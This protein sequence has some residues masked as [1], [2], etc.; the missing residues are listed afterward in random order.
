MPETKR[1]NNQPDL[2]G[3]YQYLSREL[4][5]AKD[6]LLMEVRMASAQIGSLHG[7]LKDAH[8]KSASAVSQ[9]IRFSYK[10]NQTIYDGLA[11][12]LTK[13]VGE[14]LN[15]MEEILAE[16]SKL[17]LLIDSLEELKEGYMTMQAV[18]NTTQALVD[19]EVNPKLD[20]VGTILSGEVTPKLEAIVNYLASDLNPK[21]DAIQAKQALLDDIQALA[22]E[23]N[24]KLVYL[25][26]EE[27]Y[28]RLVEA[29]SAKTEETA[30]T[31][32][33]QVV[34]AIAAL[35]TAENVDYSRIVE[36]VGD[37][38]MDILHQIKGEDPAPVLPVETK[39][40]YDRIICGAAEK[41]VESLPYPEKVDYN[42]IEQALALDPNALADT[43]A[44]RIVIPETPAPEALNYNLIAEMVAERVHVPEVTIPTLEINYDVLSDMVAE[45]VTVPAA[46]AVEIDYE[47]LSDM[48]A[49]KVTVPA[50]PAVDYGM[51]AGLV[52]GRM[53]MPAAPEVDYERIADMVAGRIEVPA[54]PA[55]PEVDYE[56]LADMVAAR[57][58]VPAAPQV[59]YDLLA[60][61]VIE[62]LAASSEQTCEIMLDEEG[63]DEIATKVAG[64]IVPSESIDYD[65]VCQAAQ[66][67][68][69]LPDPVDYD[70]IAEIVEDK[71]GAE[72]EPDY[73]LIID[74]EGVSALAKGVS[75]ELCQIC[76][77]CE[78]AVEEVCVEDVCEAPA[79]EPTEEAPEE[80]VE[81]FAFEEPTEEVIEEPVEETVEEPV[82]EVPVEE[83]IEEAPVEET[84]EEIVEEVIETPVEETVVEETPVEEAP[85]EEIAEET[86]E[87]AA[88][89]AE[90]ELAVSESAH[91][92]EVGNE[93]VDAETGLVIR[94]KRSFTAKM[95]Q[96]E[97]KVKEY[98][99]DLKNELTSYKKINSNVSWHGDRFNF[100][101]DTVAKINICGKTLCFY[102]ALD[103]NDP[104]FKSTVYHQKDVGAQKAYESTPFMVKVKSDAA[105]KKALRLVGYLAEK[106]GTEKEEN[107]EA[108]DYAGEFAYASTKQLFDE[109]FIKATKEKK[110]DLNF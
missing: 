18:C 61:I 7:D 40:D 80:I 74:E 101:R 44:S 13:E 77:S 91:Y 28:T 104:E 66:A 59:D 6:A 48:V 5:Q 103:P 89:T 87:P 71:L 69:I 29:V 26:T 73:D 108:V 46:P 62:K 24:N 94:L 60:D 9:E 2:L 17:Q 34:E 42:R 27:D 53:T 33:R 56:R 35:P 85:V 20:S 99:S 68:Q 10:Q 65:K 43:V 95:K 49:G 63:I 19:N 79:E 37:K 90:S 57:I 84:V 105:A 31:H 81:E 78:L 47:A 70:R 58:A 4:Q 88:E 96:S 8:D 82:E 36:E 39:I 16:L 86:E 32:S 25:P 102:V 15:S 106:L 38:L 100:G 54:A 107:F 75:E 55:A 21:V 14:R 97:E 92:E 109:G 72:E 52:V 98:Y 110:V 3:V 11:S 1:R 83:T 22:V 64:K 51:L 50:A 45:K 30:A 12:M 76:A 93:L 41:V 67:A 23:I